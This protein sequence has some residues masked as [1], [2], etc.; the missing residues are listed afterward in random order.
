[1]TGLQVV[2]AALD[3]NLPCSNLFSDEW[4]V[5]QKEVNGVEDVQ[6]DGPV[7]DLRLRCAFTQLLRRLLCHV[8][9]AN[10]QG[11]QGFGDL[12]LVAALGLQVCCCGTLDG[13]AG[14]VSEHQDHLGLQGGNAE[15]QAA[16]YAA[17]GVGAGVASIA[18]HK[19]V[20]RQGIK[21]GLQRCP[22]I[23]TAND[24]SVWCLSH[25]NK[26]LAHF[27][28]GSSCGRLSLDEARITLLQELQSLIRRHGRIC[29]GA[30]VPA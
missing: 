24:G 19:D 25:V 16:K 1:M 4:A 28:V 5:L 18:Q 6:L 9:E 20:T 2:D 30:H 3:L 29:G 26:L 21:D 22:G 7:H 8:A 14:C 12:R 15:L 27:L 11:I 13:S 17:F 10:Q 23:C